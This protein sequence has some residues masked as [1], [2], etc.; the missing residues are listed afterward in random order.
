MF[1]WSVR[2]GCK[3]QAYRGE[4]VK[5]QT[6]LIFLRPLPTLVS[7]P[8]FSPLA[9]GLSVAL[10]GLLVNQTGLSVTSIRLVPN[11]DFQTLR[12]DS[13]TVRELLQYSR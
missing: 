7:D 6:C 2:V 11:M 3:L 5:Y 10:P 1:T 4:S 8:N 12:D 9:T 13:P